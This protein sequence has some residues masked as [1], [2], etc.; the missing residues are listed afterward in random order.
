MLGRRITSG[1]VEMRPGV[2]VAGVRGV[3]A[4]VGVGEPDVES[5]FDDGAKIGHDA[6]PVGRRIVRCRSRAG[7]RED[8]AHLRRAEPA[9][10]GCLEN[11]L[12]CESSTVTIGDA[13]EV[14][15]KVEV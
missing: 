5:A 15:L 4:D 1:L 14:P 8:L 11:T 9:S 3:V 7:V 2:G 10:P 12:H 13:D 6:D